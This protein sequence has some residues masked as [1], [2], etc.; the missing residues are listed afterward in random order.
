MRL[1]TMV[2]REIVRFV[3]LVRIVNPENSHEQLGNVKWMLM[4]F[5]LSRQDKAIMHLDRAMVF[6]V[7]DVLKFMISFSGLLTTSGF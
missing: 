3:P 6:C 1:L 5:V 2:H 7:K 4:Y